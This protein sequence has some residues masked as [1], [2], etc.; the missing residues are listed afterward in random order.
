MQSLSTTEVKGTPLSGHG[1][2]GREHSWS[3]GYLCSTENTRQH[4]PPWNQKCTFAL[5]L[6]ENN[7]TKQKHFTAVNH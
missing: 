1:G 7:S 6:N 5:T 3:Y 4:L 2:G